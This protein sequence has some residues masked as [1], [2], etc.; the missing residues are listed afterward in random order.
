MPAP[1]IPDDDAERLAVLADYGIAPGVADAALDGVARACAHMLGTR[2]ALVTLIERQ[3]Q[4]IPAA[5]GWTWGRTTPREAAFCG[6][7]ILSDEILEIGDALDDP[8][9]ADNPL[10]TGDPY[11]RFYAGAPLVSPEGYRLGSL[12]GLDT[13]PRALATWQREA[14]RELAGTVV[15]I[16]DGYRRQNQLVHRKQQA[17]R[18]HALGQLS[19][20]M[21]HEIN[22]ALQ[23]ILGMSGVLRQ[24]VEPDTRMASLLGTMERSALYAR[25]VVSDVLAFAREQSSEDQP[26]D[27]VEAFADAVGFVQRFMPSGVRVATDGFDTVRQ[28]PGSRDVR[29]SRHGAVQV[30]QN[31][32]QNAADAMAGHGTVVVALRRAELNHAAA[33]ALDVIDSG[34]GMDAET[35]RRIFDPFFTTKLVDSG[36]GLGLAT[37]H[38]L[39]HNWG[40]RIDVDSAAGRGTRFTI[41]LPL[42]DPDAG[43]SAA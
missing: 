1:P 2:M 13:E 27:I 22:N 18:L 42:A 4:Q 20:G 12:C 31:L 25:S 24:T 30:I 17:D 36:N 15:A 43:A 5:H 37:V 41:T 38:G 7:T 14:L 28:T 26:Q 21:A 3:Q 6:Y 11:L 10:V 16:L 29:L 33:F 9:F 39:V 19:A 32:V 40:G 34:H 8:R 23:P 35:Q